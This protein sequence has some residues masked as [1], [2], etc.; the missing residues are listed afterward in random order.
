MEPGALLRVGGT[1]AG[2]GLCRG[3]RM[4]RR[5]HRTGFSAWAR[6]LLGSPP[7]SQSRLLPASPHRP[8]RLLTPVPGTASV[9][10][11]ARLVGAPGHQAPG[12]TG[13]EVSD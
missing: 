11:G 9:G 2:R 8:G 4:A 12:R 6:L 5:T 3:A 1:G 13:P 10:P 7:L